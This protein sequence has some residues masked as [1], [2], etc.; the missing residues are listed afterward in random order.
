METVLVS[1]FAV[2]SGLKPLYWSVL[3]IP[4]HC[5]EE[6]NSRRFCLSYKSKGGKTRGGFDKND[7]DVHLFFSVY[8]CT[9]WIGKKFLRFF[10]KFSFYCLTTRIQLCFNH[11]CFTIIYDLSPTLWKREDPAFIK[12]LSLFVEEVEEIHFEVVLIVELSLA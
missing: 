5:L 9:H 10:Q 6:R 8:I 2:T 11:V 7:N 4:I 1:S 12:V 3:L